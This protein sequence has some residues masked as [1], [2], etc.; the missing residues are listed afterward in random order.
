M[1]A[2][3]VSQDKKPHAMKL[4]RQALELIKAGGVRP[5]IAAEAATMIADMFFQAKVRLT[6]L[7]LAVHAAPTRCSTDL[8]P[9]ASLST[10]RLTANLE[11]GPAGFR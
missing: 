3:S 6:C 4:G 9:A 10:G 11:V 2:F 5:K 1:C 7:L 8:T